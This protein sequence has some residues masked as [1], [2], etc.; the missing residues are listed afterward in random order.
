M[1]PLVRY[2]RV[3]LAD[4]RGHRP[5]V[6]SAAGAPVLACDV[7]PAAPAGA[8]LRPGNPMGLEVLTGERTQHRYETC[9]NESCER[10]ACRVYRQ[11]Y[12]DGYEAG[13]AAG[14]AAGEAAGY[15]AG[16][17]QGYSAGVASGSR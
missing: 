15:A 4:L 8:V 7:T 5:G 11:G 13:Q 3:A 17:S 9:R 10:F 2:A 6:A 12:Q 16:Y 14:Y 1:T